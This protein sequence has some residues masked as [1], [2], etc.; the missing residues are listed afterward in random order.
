MKTAANFYKRHAALRIY[1][2]MILQ[3]SG[4]TLLLLLACS[5]PSPAWTETVGLKT[6]IYQGLKNNHEL[7]ALHAQ[8]EQARFTMA[9]NEGALGLQVSAQVNSSLNADRNDDGSGLTEK[10]YLNVSGALALTYP[11]YAPESNQQ[12]AVDTATIRELELRLEE[13]EL[14]V[15]EEVFDIYINILSQ[16][17]QLRTL[18]AELD[19]LSTQQQNI[20][21]RF[22]NGTGNQLE[23]IEIQADYRLLQANLLEAEVQQQNHYSDLNILTGLNAQQV[24]LLKS[25]VELPQLVADT[26][27]YWRDKAQS[28][29]A[30]LRI[31]RQA[32]QTA[33]EKSTLTRKR[34]GLTVDAT[35]QWQ[36]GWNYE[37]TDFYENGSRNLGF[38][39]AYPLYTNGVKQADYQQAAAA[40]SIAREELSAAQQDID[41]TIYRLVQLLLAQQEIVTAR[42]LAIDAQR[43]RL[44]ATQIGIENSIRNRTELLDVQRAL[45]QS[46]R[47]YYVAIYQ[48][49][50]DYFRLLRHSGSI[51][52]DDD[53]TV[54]YTMLNPTE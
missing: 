5:A 4:Y 30:N 2:T 29:N 50:S 38:S 18:K 28:N 42:A 9:I 35:A 10:H 23:L 25:D 1:F 51:E 52:E 12:L 47:D 27:E 54:F 14:S 8:V 13:N 33:T 15:I 6:A 21:T 11:L 31:L 46:E 40:S 20:Q 17:D 32:V 7:A 39:F 49:L 45:F 26:I 48:Y 36:P 41:R 3:K 19:T 22:E 44:R 16:H 24:Y 43:E 53:M 37:H 34:Y